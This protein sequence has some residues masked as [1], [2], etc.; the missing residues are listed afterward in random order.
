MLLVTLF[1]PEGDWAPRSWGINHSLYVRARSS[2]VSRTV[3]YGFW[4]FS[5]A[6]SPLGG[7]EVYGVKSLGSDTLGYLSYEIGGANNHSLSQNQ[8]GKSHHGIVTPYA[9]FLAL[10]YAPRQA[11]ANLRALTARFPIY[12]E[13]GFHDSVDISAGVVARCILAIPSGHDHGRDR[14]R[15]GR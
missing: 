4:G 5:P 10:R 8:G 14:Q 12:S 6:A 7:Y 3:H 15:A 1:V 11:V 13:F 2:M 9:S